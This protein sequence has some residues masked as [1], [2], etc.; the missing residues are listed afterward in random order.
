[1]KARIASTDFWERVESS[2]GVSGGV[3]KL[4]C[5]RAVDSCEI[6]PVQRLLGEDAGGVLYIGMAESFID[7]VIDLKKSLS[8]THRSKRHECGVRMKEHVAISE[9]FPYD[10]LV[11]SLISSDAPRTLESKELKDYFTAFGE[12]P[13]L[14]R[15][16]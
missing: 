4:A 15:T 7:R 11:V 14:N 6:I 9:A 16:C 12:L 10:R 1:M 13:P 8:P 2:F 5:L 3:Y